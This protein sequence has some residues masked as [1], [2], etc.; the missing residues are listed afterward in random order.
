MMSTSGSPVAPPGDQRSD[1][2]DLSHV[3]DG[4]RVALVLDVVEQQGLSVRLTGRRPPVTPHPRRQRLRLKVK[5]TRRLLQ[6]QLQPSD[7]A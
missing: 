1:P 2:P 5:V 7:G 3:L 4:V 6:L